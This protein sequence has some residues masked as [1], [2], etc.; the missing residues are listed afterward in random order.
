MCYLNLWFSLG[1]NFYL[2]LY[3][4][5]SSLCFL[6]GFFLIRNSCLCFFF[7]LFWLIT[8][9][10]PWLCRQ[11]LLLN[12]FLIDCLMLDQLLSF[13][14]T[15][16]VLIRI[17][18]SLFLDASLFLF[19]LWSFLIPLF[20]SRFLLCFSSSLPCVLP[21]E[22]LEVCNTLQSICVA[23]FLEIDHRD[24]CKFYSFAICSWLEVV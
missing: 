2:L 3:G 7:L 22:M 14:L 4:L 20:R 17:C 15:I 9:A 23:I 8:Y 16:Q 10:Y 5:I 11:F 18:S 6:F 12:F 13:A 1:S 24:V 19:F 21:Q